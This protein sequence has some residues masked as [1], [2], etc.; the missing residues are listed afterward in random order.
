[1]LLLLFRKSKV[2][3][4][5]RVLEAEVN[6]HPGMPESIFLP[7]KRERC[8]YGVRLDRERERRRGTG[9]EKRPQKW[10]ESWTGRRGRWL[11]KKYVKLLQ[12]FTFPC[13]TT[14]NCEASVLTTGQRLVWF[15]CS[16]NN[17]FNK[18]GLLS[19]ILRPY[20]L[21]CNNLMYH[22]AKPGQF[23]SDLVQWLYIR[24]P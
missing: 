16:L 13:L 14:S 17:T 20:Y 11:W 7:L 22:C 15:W 8:V 5:G 1:M 24:I 23:I 18:K 3:G 6:A 21:E 4:R 2:G 9:E 19:I 10:G 12:N